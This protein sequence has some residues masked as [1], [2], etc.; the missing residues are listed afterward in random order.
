MLITHK[1]MILQ[2]V[3]Y[4]KYKDLKIKARENRGKILRTAGKLKKE[5][6][7]SLMNYNN[8]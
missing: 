3:I 7:F 5:V 1:H 6:K 4:S 2:E 8:K